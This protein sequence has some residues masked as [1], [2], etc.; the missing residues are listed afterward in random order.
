MGNTTKILMRPYL[1][2]CDE[3]CPLENLK[4]IKLTI[5]F[6][7]TENNKEIP[8]TI[9]INNIQLSYDKEYCFEFQVPHKLVKVEF[10]LSGKIENKSH[11]FKD[12]LFLKEQYYFIYPK[13]YDFLIKKNDKG[14]YIF[15]L[16]GKNGE[17]KPN[18]QIGLK[19]TH[20]YQKEIN[21]NQPILLESDH[22]GIIDLGQ[23]KDINSLEIDSKKYFLD[24][25]PKHVYLPKIKILE[26]QELYLP[27]IS[28]EKNYIN[29]FKL[30]N[31]N[32]SDNLS[33]L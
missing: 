28:K 23:L 27:F 5:N 22:E 26:N 9:V 2:V 30:Y 18:Y 21:K 6:T 11:D 33:N 31:K 16:L 29:L 3:I 32:I 10:I 24:K 1:F 17:P 13:D 25:L 4:N 14:N 15:H 8:S 12:T 7:K 20:N 19:L